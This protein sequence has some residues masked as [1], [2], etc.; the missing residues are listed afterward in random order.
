MRFACLPIKLM[1]HPI[2]FNIILA[3]KSNDEPLLRFSSY[4]LIFLNRPRRD[5]YNNI[6]A[7]SFVTKAFFEMASR[8]LFNVILFVGR[9]SMMLRHRPSL[10]VCKTSKLRI[11]ECPLIREMQVT[12]KLRE[13]KL[14]RVIPGN[15]IAHLAYIPCHS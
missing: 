10:S 1:T 4:F 8:I 5:P 7:H 11:F 6:V 14:L 12:V 2:L 3:D 9:Y 13:S 15:K